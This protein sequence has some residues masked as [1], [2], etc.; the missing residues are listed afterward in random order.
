MR[1]HPLLAIFA[2]TTSPWVTT[3]I[4]KPGMPSARMVTIDAGGPLWRPAPVIVNVKLPAGL[5]IVIRP[6]KRNVSNCA[7]AWS[8]LGE[9]VLRALAVGACAAGDAQS[10]QQEGREKRDSAHGNLI[11]GSPA[12]A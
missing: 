10:R 7:S 3:D 8:D 9:K 2:Q 12:P 6:A 11:G 4:G 1:S 5:S